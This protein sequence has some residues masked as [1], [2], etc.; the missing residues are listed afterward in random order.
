M[1]VLGGQPDV[2]VRAQ[3]PGHLVGEELAHAP[4]G[5]PAHDLADEEPLGERVVPGR[6]ARLPLRS[7]RGQPCGGG[8]PV[9]EILGRGRPSQSGRPAVCASRCRTSTS[10]LPAAA[11]S[12]QYRA[13]GASRSSSPRSARM[14]GA[15]RCHRLGDGPDVGDR[16][17]LPR[18]RAVRVGEP[19]PDV[20]HR[21][22]VHEDS[23]R[24]THV[25]SVQ[26]RGQ[27]A[28]YRGEQIVVGT[29]NLGHVRNLARCARPRSTGF[30]GPMALMYLDGYVTMLVHSPHGSCSAGTGGR[31]P[32]DDAGDLGQRSGHRG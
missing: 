5:D 19:A 16:V 22:A 24:G 20:H 23:D 11:N 25:S 6:G 28:G 15:Q 10:S 18:D 3:R 21:L 12:G 31:E 7:L 2:E 26:Q 17:A 32:A 14:Q 8:R 13:T 4:A 29:L 27:R 9:V 30:A 1:V